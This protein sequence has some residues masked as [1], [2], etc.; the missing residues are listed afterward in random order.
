MQHLSFDEED[1]LVGDHRHQHQNKK[2]GEYAGRVK[3]AAGAQHV[4]AKPA[5]GANQFA[6]DRANERQADAD[7]E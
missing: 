3:L 6:H 4:P 5:I 1:D 7:P 2:S